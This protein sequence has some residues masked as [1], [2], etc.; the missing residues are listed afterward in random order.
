MLAIAMLEAERAKVC[1]FVCFFITSFRNS[2]V[3]FGVRFD[4]DL[5][6]RFGRA[7]RTGAKQCD[8][9]RNARRRSSG[10]VRV[11]MRSI[12]V[13]THTRAFGS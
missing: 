4:D 11:R 3:F 10:D 5:R 6:L 12:C 8:H 13:Y 9:R 7:G 2:F 1:L